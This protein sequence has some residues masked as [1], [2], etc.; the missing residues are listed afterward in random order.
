MPLEQ[1]VRRLTG[2]QADLYGIVDRGY[3]R[4]GAWA[5]LVVFDP[6]TIAPGPVRTVPE[7]PDGS[8]RLTSSA[9]GIAH[10]V[11]NGTPIVREGGL[12]ATRPAACFGRAETP[13]PSA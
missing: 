6:D 3:V 8:D 9:H 1:A 13:A 4:E 2:V 11:V 10:V 7:L 5:D 12:T